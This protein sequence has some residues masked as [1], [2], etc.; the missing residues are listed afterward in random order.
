MMVSCKLRLKKN[1][2]RITPEMAQ[3]LV[4]LGLIKVV[5]IG[6]FQSVVKDDLEI[7]KYLRA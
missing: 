2:I 3:K 1:T 7:W 6:K 5:E 4:Q